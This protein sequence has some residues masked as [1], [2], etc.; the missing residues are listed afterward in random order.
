MVADPSS[1]L[2]DMESRGLNRAVGERMAQGYNET[3]ARCILG[4]YRD[5][6]QPRMTRLGANFPPLLPARAWPC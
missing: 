1:R 3:M 5:A 2:D 4:L 6:A